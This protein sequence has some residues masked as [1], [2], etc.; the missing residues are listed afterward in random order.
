MKGSACEL[1]D[2]LPDTFSQ[3]DVIGFSRLRNDGR[4]EVDLEPE[5]FAGD[6]SAAGGLQHV[7]GSP[8]LGQPFD[9]KRHNRSTGL[10]R[11]HG[12][13]RAPRPV[14]VRL[15]IA[16]GLARWK[17]TENRLQPPETLRVLEEVDH[18][19]G[20]HAL[21]NREDDAFCISHQAKDGETSY[22]GRL[23]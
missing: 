10:A 17:D 4:T 19:G 23:W 14:H 1:E 15:K 7:E 12:C 13:T 22:S 8:V 6:E 5:G 2:S 3:L 18:R 16:V 20:G 11:G 21:L 9:V